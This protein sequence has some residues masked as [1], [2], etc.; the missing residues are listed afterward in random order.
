MREI[1]TSGIWGCRP[2]S[3][4]RPTLHCGE[5]Q[6]NCRK[7]IIQDQTVTSAKCGS[8]W[9]RVARHM[10]LNSDLDAARSETF[11]SSDCLGKNTPDMS[12]LDII[13]PLVLSHWDDQHT[14]LVLWQELRA[15]QH[16]EATEPQIVALAGAGYQTAHLEIARSLL[17]TASPEMRLNGTICTIWEALLFLLMAMTASILRREAA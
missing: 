15:G 9:I 11:H 16:R 8:L 7:G 2:H 6:F 14:P 17:S 3:I 13:P 12:L 1:K 5:P 4:T 10:K